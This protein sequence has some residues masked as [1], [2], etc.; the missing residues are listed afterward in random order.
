MLRIK[1]SLLVLALVAFPV[2]AADLAV[3]WE[4]PTMRED[5]TPLDAS[6]IAN[7]TLNCGGDPITIPAGVSEYRVPGSD[8]FPRYGPHD[9][10]MTTVDIN[11]LESKPS[12]PFTV[13]WVAP[14]NPPTNILIIVR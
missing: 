10:Y 11:G 5:G 6:E 8:I 9:C 13:D 2:A 14:P 12:E 4:A 7:Y 3:T 1:N